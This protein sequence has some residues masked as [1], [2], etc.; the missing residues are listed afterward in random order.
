MSLNIQLSLKNYESLK[1]QFIEA[2]TAIPGLS[3]IPFDFYFDD[4]DGETLKF[5]KPQLKATGADQ[6]GDLFARNDENGHKTFSL[7]D[8]DIYELASILEHAR[9]YELKC[10]VNHLV[11]IKDLN[12]LGFVSA[13]DPDS[14]VYT[15][16]DHQFHQ[17]QLEQVFFEAF[18]DCLLSNGVTYRPEDKEPIQNYFKEAN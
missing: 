18:L 14:K 13:I 9:K 1:Y 7:Y 16:D 11:F 2:I 3:S 10:S 15:I 6:S 17:D 4:P 8:L 5:H 12:Q